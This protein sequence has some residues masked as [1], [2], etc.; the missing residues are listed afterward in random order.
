MSDNVYCPFIL[1]VLL[2]K[3]L[4]IIITKYNSMKLLIHATLLGHK[5]FK[6]FLLDIY[7]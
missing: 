4:I 6:V 7:K 2:Y 1:K 5:T 3:Y